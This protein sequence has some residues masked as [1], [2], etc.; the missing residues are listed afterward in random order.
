M[1]PR[2]KVKP[3]LLRWA[4]QRSQVDPKKLRKRFPKY[5][6]WESGSLKPTLKQLE[7][8]ARFTHVPIGSLFMSKPMEEE[9]P[10]QDLRTM[11]DRKILQ[12]SDNLLDTIYMCM[13]RQ[14]WYQ[15]FALAE[16]EEPLPFV[17]SAT[18]ESDVEA[19]AAEIQTTLGFGVEERKEL[20]NWSHALRYFTDQADDLGILVMISG[21]VR[22]NT[23]RKL[24]PQEFRG[25]ALADEL[26]PL[27]FI[28]GADT[29]AA[30]IFT[31]AHELVHIWLGESSLSN[32]APNSFPAHVTEKW[33]NQVAAELLVPTRSLRENFR[34]GTNISDEVQRLASQY[35]V[36][37]LVILRRLHDIGGIERNEFK[38]H[39]S[40]ELDRL[41]PKRRGGGGGNFHTTL[42]TRVGRRFG[43]AL[44]SSTLSGQTFFT[45]AFYYL[46]I[47]K[48]STLNA[49]AKSLWEG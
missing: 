8:F 22:G 31:L 1:T 6:D 7:D 13:Q 9:M 19:V 40:Y 16:G 11:G 37:T 28:N 34:D 44:V 46:G 23:H 41:K 2:V 47:R 17:G 36:S 21:I 18:V 26:A 3:E 33:C 29:K 48:A 24:D 14:D 30:Q 27:I 39:Y 32:A 4:C 38:V 10:I 42:K 12:P 15:T 20:Q 5:G 45:D 49:F 25:F 35:K 43:E